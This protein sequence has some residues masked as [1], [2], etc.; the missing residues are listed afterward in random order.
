MRRGEFR[1]ALDAFDFQRCLGIA[2]VAETLIVDVNRRA[3]ALGRPR[4]N[5]AR[6]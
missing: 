4:E 3:T 2:F 5:F 1:A 6:F